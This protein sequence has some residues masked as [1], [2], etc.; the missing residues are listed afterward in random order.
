ML[1]LR[2]LFDGRAQ[3]ADG[4]VVGETI[5]RQHTQGD[6]ATGLLVGGLIDHAQVVH[7]GEAL[8]H[9]AGTDLSPAARVAPP[10]APFPE[11]G[12]GVSVGLCVS[13]SAMSERR[14]RVLFDEQPR[15]PF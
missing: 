11:L 6:S 5:R 1:D 7:P 2:R 4:V 15:D 10:A 13:G 14:A 8:D 12:S 3:P 9:E